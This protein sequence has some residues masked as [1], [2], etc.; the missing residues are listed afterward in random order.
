M[1]KKKFKKKGIIFKIGIVITAIIA[2]Y[3]LPSVIAEKISY[4]KIKNTS[5]NQDIMG[6]EEQDG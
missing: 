6:D 5:I 4:Q 2:F 1:N 3:K